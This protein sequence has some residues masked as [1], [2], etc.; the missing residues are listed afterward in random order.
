MN[1]NKKLI[2]VGFAFRHHKETQAGY[3]H[4]KDYLNYDKIIDCQWEHEWL[5]DPS[6]SILEKLFRKIHN[7]LFGH[8]YTFTIIKCILLAIFR[9][10]QIFHFIYVENSY[11]WLHHFKGKTNKIVCTYHQPYEII[12][13]R[14]FWKSDLSY[15]D[16]A[17][18]LAKKDLSLFK[19]GTGKENV[20]FIPHGINTDFYT[21]NV[22]R[23]REYKILMVGNWLRDFE[24]ASSIFETL[25]ANCLKLTITIVTN[26]SN[27]SHFKS[28]ERL[29]LLSGISDE[30]LGDLYCTT[31]CLF[32]PLQAFAANNAILEAAATGCPIVIASDK[33][34]TSYFE[35]DLVDFL[36]LQK[37][38]VYEHLLK[39][40]NSEFDEKKSENL[41]KTTV[42]NF[43]WQI[44][45]NRTKQLLLN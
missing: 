11:K 15:I 24:F 2:Y 21:P 8:G 43:S 45:A 18:I 17:I 19:L 44:I 35:R 7:R 28:N 37:E 20:Y 1:H 12:D 6:K 41:R 22:D 3:H 26:K 9:K 34:D 25:L 29:H 40:L 14:D 30:E 4:I 42:E 13:T 36:P 39:I 23:K 10:N 27:F 33:V 5:N 16:K 38:L 32:L 31:K